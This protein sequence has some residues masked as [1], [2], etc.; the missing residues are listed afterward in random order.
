MAQ[1]LP[2]DFRRPLLLIELSHAL[3]VGLLEVRLEL[4]ERASVGREELDQVVDA[5]FA[6]R[7]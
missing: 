2:T 1:R 6:Q 4:S 5:A 3:Q 7:D